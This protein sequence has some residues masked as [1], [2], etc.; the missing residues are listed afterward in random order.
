MYVF[1]AVFLLAVLMFGWFKFGVDDTALVAEL[2]APQ[3]ILIFYKKLQDSVQKCQ[4]YGV[5]VAENVQAEE[6]IAQIKKEN[7]I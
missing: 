4:F 7:K 6:K 2:L 3:P 1:P 5:K